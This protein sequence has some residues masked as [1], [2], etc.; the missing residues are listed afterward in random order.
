M[1][2]IWL[3]VL[4]VVLLPSRADAQGRARFAFAPY[5][6]G[7]APGESRGFVARVGEADAL[8]IDRIDPGV[9]LGAT[10]DLWWPSS[11][12]RTRITG[13]VTPPLDADG[14]FACMTDQPCLASFIGADASA[15]I[16]AAVVDAVVNLF[17]TDPVK[18]YA[19]L[20]AGIKRYSFSWDTPNPSTSDGSQ[21]ENALA[22]HAAVGFEWQMWGSMIHLEVSDYWSPSADRIE[23]A[24]GSGGVAVPGR[25]A[26]HD[27]SI[28]VGYRL[29]RF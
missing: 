12:V 2:K 23:P 25:R 24:P 17:E 27:L 15:R 26:Q 13:L 7:I 4:I 1:K 16:A 9:V 5:V 6:G 19:I 22:I 8:F 3:L 11:R 10:A 28:T 18:P 14:H 29:F 20:G 21:A